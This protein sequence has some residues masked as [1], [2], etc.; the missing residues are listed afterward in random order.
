MNEYPEGFDASCGLPAWAMRK[1]NTTAASMVRDRQWDVP[2]IAAAI[3]SARREGMDLAAK[4]C[5]QLGEA[6]EGSS[7]GYEFEC[8]AAIRAQIQ[9]GK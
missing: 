5:E 9:E 3:V 8:A 2:C 1:A 4:I 7:E 6:P